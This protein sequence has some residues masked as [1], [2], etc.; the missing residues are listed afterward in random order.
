MTRHRAFPSLG[1]AKE[2]FCLVE[3][4][5]CRKTPFVD[6]GVDWVKPFFDLRSLLFVLPAPVKTAEGEFDP[7][8]ILVTVEMGSCQSIPGLVSR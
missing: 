6:G 7:I 1:S 8:P 2:M 3:R 5:A 4:Q